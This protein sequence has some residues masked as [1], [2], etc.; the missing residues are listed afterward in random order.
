MID[1]GKLLQKLMD[2]IKQ[3]SDSTFGETDRRIGMVG[4][5]EREAD[6]VL[7]AILDGDESIIQQEITDCFILVLDLAA[8]TDMSIAKLL[9]FAQN[10]HEIN[11]SRKWRSPNEN[12]SVEHIENE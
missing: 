6:E 5:L 10:K 3:W 12:G 2:D 9:F 7:E 11:K 4:H 1:T 8:H